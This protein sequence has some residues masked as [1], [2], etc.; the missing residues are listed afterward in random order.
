[1]LLLT[2]KFCRVPFIDSNLHFD[3][4]F[5]T[6]RGPKTFAWISIVEPADSISHAGALCRRA[7]NARFLATHYPL[8]KVFKTSSG[9]AAGEK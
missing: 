3:G 4:Q 1:M 6:V 7:F 5:S 8:N 2:L 9:S